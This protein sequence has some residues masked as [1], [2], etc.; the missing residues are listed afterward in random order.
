M[1]CASGYGIASDDTLLLQEN[2][3]N[4]VRELFHTILQF[5][6]ATASLHSRKLFRSIDICYKQDTFYNY[7]LSESARRDKNFDIDRVG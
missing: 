5:R 2:I 6:E 4:Q 3:L 1:I 7:C